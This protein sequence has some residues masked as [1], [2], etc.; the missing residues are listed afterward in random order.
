M[1]LANIRSATDWLG[2]RLAPILSRVR[3]GSYQVAGGPEI[4]FEDGSTYQDIADL[5]TVI[6]NEQGNGSANLENAQVEDLGRSILTGYPLS[7][8]Q[9]GILKRLLAK[10]APQLDA[11]R[12]SGD[13]EGQDYTAVPDP[14]TARIV[15]G[16]TV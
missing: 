3:E 13:R 6:A 1:D 15:T 9:I 2:D 10:Y 4:Y 14:G 7:D 5:Y 8:V 11:L 12:G 16:G